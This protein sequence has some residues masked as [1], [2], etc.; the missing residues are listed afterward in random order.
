MAEQIVSEDVHKLLKVNLLHIQV[1]VLKGTQKWKFLIRYGPGGPVANHESCWGRG[2]FTIL[3][4]SAEL[5]AS[6]DIAIRELIDLLKSHE[7]AG[8]PTDYFA[9]IQE[10]FVTQSLVQVHSFWLEEEATTTSKAGPTAAMMV[11]PASSSGHKPAKTRQTTSESERD[12]RKKLSRKFKEKDRERQL[13]GC[14]RSRG[15]TG[16]STR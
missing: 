16:H 9:R 4:Q 6:R 15:S 5:Y 10:A 8:I 3:F 14:N 11:K 1:E 2:M 12:R 7:T 13:S